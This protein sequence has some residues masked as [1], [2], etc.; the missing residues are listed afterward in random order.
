MRAIAVP[1][2]YYN[3]AINRPFYYNGTYR[4]SGCTNT[5]MYYNLCFC[6]FKGKHCNYGYGN[7]F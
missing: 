2:N 3:T 1:I 5:G 4:R 7:Y 6:A